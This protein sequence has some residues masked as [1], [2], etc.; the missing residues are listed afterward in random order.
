MIEALPYRKGVG[1]VIFNNFGLVW[2]GRRISYPTKKITDN[3]QM[4]Q[5]GIDENETPELAILREVKEETGTEMVE[6]IDKAKGWIDYD[7]PENLVGVAW[8]GRFRGQRQQWF[9]LR[10]TGKNTDFDLT[11]GR[12][13]EFSEWRWAELAT[14]PELIVP[15]KRNLYVQI[16]AEFRHWPDKIQAQYS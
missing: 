8:N 4:P 14:L 12:N 15:F 10:F 13:P 6:L 16:A 9:A 2:L 11:A 3:W 1:A 7:L 5:G